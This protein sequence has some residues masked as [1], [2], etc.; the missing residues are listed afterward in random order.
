LK[1]QGINSRI[2]S[3]EHYPNRKCP[4]LSPL[5]KAEWL[6]WFTWIWWRKFSSDIILEEEGITTCYSSKTEPEYFH[7]ELTDILNPKVPQNS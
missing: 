7:L 5:S 3:F 2:I 4:A 6:L 1:I